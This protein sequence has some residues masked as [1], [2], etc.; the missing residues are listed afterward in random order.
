MT[1]HATRRKCLLLC[2][3][4]LATTAVAAAQEA[5]VAALDSLL[6]DTRTMSADVAQVI[7][8]S[9][10]GVLEESVIAMHMKRP[11]GFYWETLEP[12]PE[13]VVTNGKLLW[14]YQPDLEQVVVEPWDSDRS[15]LAAQLLQGQTETLS[16]DYVIERL[17]EEGASL[18]EFRLRPLAGDSIYAQIS[19]SF[20]GPDLDTIHLR[21]T[22]GE[23]T[24]W[25][26]SNVR[27]NEPLHDDLFEFEPPPGIEV[28][29]N[30]QVP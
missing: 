5:P 14:N 19:I 1:H 21:Q 23:Q 25:R 12:F 24:V 18:S 26:F 28:I 8:E 15:E 16:R 30:E 2:L 11:D 29:E 13:L 9:D 4:G 6:G 3:A 20:V 17:S 27:R 22:N 7:V 10:G